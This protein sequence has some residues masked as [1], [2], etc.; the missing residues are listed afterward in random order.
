MH[1]KS[2]T[3]P[4][5]A[6]LC[7]T[8][9]RSKRSKNNTAHTKIREDKIALRIAATTGRIFSELPESTRASPFFGTQ[10]FLCRNARLKGFS[11][12]DTLFEVRLYHFFSVYHIFS[13]LSMDFQNFFI[14]VIKQAE[15]VDPPPCFYVLYFVTRP[16]KSAMIM[17]PSSVS[18]GETVAGEPMRIR[19]SSIA[20]FLL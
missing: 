19:R 10:P 6:L 14:F 2:R 12:A 8:E 9:N 15:D 1:E 17:P 3:A 20:V 18:T 5:K 4:R 7:T 16:K 13:V 11:T